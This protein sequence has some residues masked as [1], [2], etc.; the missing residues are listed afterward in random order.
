M[1]VSVNP[2]HLGTRTTAVC[3][4]NLRCAR[5]RLWNRETVEAERIERW[6]QMGNFARTDSKLWRV[7]GDEKFL[8]NGA[9]GDYKI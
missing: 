3:A 5:D 8:D 1:V 6:T 9:M 4:G 2:R 7:M